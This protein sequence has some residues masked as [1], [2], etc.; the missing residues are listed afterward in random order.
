MMV[1][2]STE[3]STRQATAGQMHFTATIAAPNSGATTRTEYTVDGEDIKVAWEKGDEI[4]LIHNGVK[5]V[6]TVKFVNDNGS[7]IIGGSFT[8]TPSDGDDVAL[9]YP[10]ARV[11]GMT[12]DGNPVLDED[13]SANMFKQD[14]TLDYIQDNLDFREDM[15]TL[16]VDGTKV[17]LTD[18]A[19]M[20]SG[21]AIWKLTLQDSG[22]TA[23]AAKQ[24]KI[25]GGGSVLA[26][27]TTL[28]TAT[29]EVTLA[30]PTNIAV[31]G[32]LTIEATV[33][34]DTYAY[35]KAE[36]ATFWP[37]Q[38]YQSTVKLTKAGW[39][40][41]EYNEGKWN[42]TLEKVEFTKKTADS[43]PQEI[44]NGYDGA[45]SLGWYTVT[46]DNV[47]INWDITLSDDLYLILCDGAKLTINGRLNVGNHNLYIYGQEKGD[48]KLN[49]T[50]NDN[51]ITS[52]EDYRIEIHGGE[53]TAEATG[54]GNLALH[55]GYLAVYGGKLTATSGGDNGIIFKNT[56]DVYG[57]EVV[58][59]SNATSSLTPCFGIVSPSDSAS[60]ILTVYGGK[61]TATGNGV[62]DDPGYGSGFEC[63]VKSG[64]SGTSGIK[65]YFS[66]DGT[67]WGDGTG[68]AS[69]TRVGSN[70]ATKK[71]YAK[72]E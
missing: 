59:T 12:S 51:A 1:A 19:D 14:G 32:A 40:A 28:S 17:T 56:I 65:F 29:S 58:A 8:G 24:V 68:Y 57:G 13:V 69:A 16:S 9:V 33:G 52:N 47:I 72:A 30:I 11:S 7:A 3:D 44:A 66:A 70:D 34:D 67:T 36:G 63:Y 31:D 4:A 37:S 6:A 39:A 21:I 60:K 23:L 71:R 55:T 54:D 61:V 26:S 18:A 41:N 2:C 48:G 43:D 5:D 42:S 49:V 46:G 27:T 62:P 38:Y 45:I 64:T 22:E 20:S 25:K 10:A 35:T 53:V 15:N 50:C